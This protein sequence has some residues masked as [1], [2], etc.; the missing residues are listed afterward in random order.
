[1]ARVFSGWDDL[2]PEDIVPWKDGDEAR[3]EAWLKTARTPSPHGPV[4]NGTREE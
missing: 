3:I 2:E 4:R 1:M